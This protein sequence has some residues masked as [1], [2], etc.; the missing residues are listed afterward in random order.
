MELG[1]EDDRKLVRVNGKPAIGIGVAKQSKAIRLEVAQAV[2]QAWPELA[3]PLPEGI[4]LR[5]AWDASL[6]IEL[7]IREG[8]LAL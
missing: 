4:T 6:A 3:A 7:S 5:V 1:A 8:Y 2:N